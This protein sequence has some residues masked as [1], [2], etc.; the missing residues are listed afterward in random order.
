MVRIP[1]E[2]EKDFENRWEAFCRSAES[3]A[4]RP[5]EAPGFFERLKLVFTLS[6]FVAESCARRP[7]IFSD[8]IASGDLDR[9]YEPGEYGGMLEKALSGVVDEPSLSKALRLFRCRETI[10]IAWRDLSNASNLA[11]TMEDLTAFAETVLDRS[12]AYLYRWQCER[13]GTPVSSD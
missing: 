8:L 2:L 5:W 13:C 10:R 9:S 7:G 12:L 4:E 1:E 6:E 3:L 11:E